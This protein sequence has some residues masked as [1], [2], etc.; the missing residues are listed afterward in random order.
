MRIASFPAY[1][2]TT[3]ILRN[4]MNQL[5]MRHFMCDESISH[6]SM[7]H[8]ITTDGIVSG[9]PNDC[10]IEDFINYIEYCERIGIEFIT[11]DRLITMKS[12]AACKK[13][14]VIT[15][16]DGYESMYSVAAKE[17]E[18]R[19]IPFLCF[20]VTSFVGRKGFVSVN[21]LKDLSKNPLCTIGMHSDRHIFWRGKS[22][23]ELRDDY[24]KCRDVL[25][26]ITGYEPRYYAFPYGSCTAVSS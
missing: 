20:I 10:R 22:A 9:N 23:E 15:F 11:I 14:A 24:I 17:L 7:F 13:K 18:K 1:I 21:Q 8:R 19:A 16:D 3:A 4:K 6:I 12:K 5:I 26:K 25:G 2:S